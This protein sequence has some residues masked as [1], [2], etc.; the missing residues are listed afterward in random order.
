M[1]WKGAGEK[2]VASDRIVSGNCLSTTQGF[3]VVKK[4]AITHIFSS[5]ET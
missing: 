3:S 2:L 1:I 4:L 5:L